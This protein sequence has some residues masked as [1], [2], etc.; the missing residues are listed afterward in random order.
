MTKR[1]TQEQLVQLYRDKG[2]D[3]LI[4]YA[5]RNALRALPVLGLGPPRVLRTSW[6]N[7]T[8]REVYSVCRILILLA[9]WFES[10]ERV[11]FPLIAKPRNIIHDAVAA[12][13]F[14]AAA[15]TTFNSHSE[16]DDTEYLAYLVANDAYNS[17][18]RASDSYI[19]ATLF[20]SE[21][22][23]SAKLIP[24][25]WIKTS[26]ATSAAASID[27]AAA[28]D[29]FLLQNTKKI[30]SSFWLNQPLWP[31]GRSSESEQFRMGS[32]RFLQAL[33]G[34]GLEFLAGDINDLWSGCD[35]KPHVKN[36]FNEYSEVEI[37]KPD[38]LSSL[39]LGN[40]DA[41]KIHA[42]RVLLLGPGGAGKS[43]LADRLQDKEVEKVKRMTPGVDY[44]H[45]QSLNLQKTFPNFGLA[46]KQ[47]DLF[48]WD[49]GG[50]TIFH[51]LHRA[52]LHE[53]CVYV[54]VVDSRHEQAPDEWLHQ[55]RH[56]SGSETK[57]L[58]VTNQYEKCKT[59]QNET[60]LLREFSDLLSVDSFFYFSCIDCIPEVG[61]Q[62][63]VTQLFQNGLDSQK[64]VLKETLDVQKALHKHYQ[65]KNNVFLELDDL[66]NVIEETT[67]K[68]NI[69]EEVADKLQQLG[70]LVKVDHHETS[71]CLKPEW[72]IDHSY[73]L[74]H[75][76]A[77]RDSNG[78]M[79][80]KS[81]KQCFE[82]S[83][84]AT[85]ITHLVNFLQERSLCQKL[86]SSDEYFFP[87]AAK[88]NEPELVS[89]ILGNE[90]ALVIRFD[91]PYLPLGF[92][93]H[94]VHNMFAVSAE[95]GIQNPNDIWRQG[96]II[97]KG[98][99]QAVVQYLLRKNVIEMAF[100]GS[101]KD[102]YSE[103]LNIFI[104]N[105]KTAIANYDGSQIQDV[106][107]SVM[108]NKQI[109]SVH[110]S[111]ALIKV[112]QQI[113]SYDELIDKVSEMASKKYSVNVGDNSNVAID[114]NYI[115]QKN[116]SDNQT[117]RIDIDQRQQITGVIA[118]LLKDA[119]AL[120]TDQLS[121]VVQVRAALEG[122]TPEN[123][124]LLSRVWT[125]LSDI[126]DFTNNA[127]GVGTFVVENQPKIAA[128]LALATAVIG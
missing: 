48:L 58:L 126:A 7:K 82:N 16:N 92:H 19:N 118:E 66:E 46:Q 107:P 111:E 100:L 51:G 1:P 83:P 27:S 104:S 11:D 114:A 74:L 97:R 39:I 20:A 77:L 12:V 119:A 110:S 102:D 28:A 128:A 86:R 55:I 123:N 6:K 38:I 45:H 79:A 69:T 103:L 34:L 23:K 76:A 37:K 21:A 47:L 5:W 75:S 36:Y 61:F 99:S 81:L 91:M 30:D 2:H 65:D 80:S 116:D 29:Y 106:H 117:L 64:M 24:E 49:F 41:D 121:A 31:N 60:R 108:L 115:V 15:T 10:S 87:D 120:S 113:K 40:E 52:F 94:L 13:E 70:F 72:V 35:L 90:N 105:L 54:L 17:A 84:K 33:T 22:Y 32:I 89:E 62:H 57:V 43:S 125:G 50:Q 14:A 112:L 63:F 59:S 8:T 124:N 3:A 93:A 26:H 88:A 9:Q 98:S 44:Q 95:V 122:E 4:W 25:D 71:Y 96:F 78:L 68:T 109:F 56:L 101:L 85:Y 18:E 127:I 42:V 67:S 53:N 73:E